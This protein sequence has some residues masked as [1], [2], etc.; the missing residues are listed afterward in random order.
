MLWNQKVMTMKRQDLDK[1]KTFRLKRIVKWAWENSEFYRNFWKTKGFD[2]EQVKDWKD[3]VKIPI[4]RKDDLR[5]D[6]SKNPPFGPSWS[7]S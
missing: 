1:I 7:Q 5:N 3:I 2:P 4:L 6:L